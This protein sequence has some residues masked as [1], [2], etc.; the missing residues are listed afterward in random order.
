VKPLPVFPPAGRLFRGFLLLVFFVFWTLPVVPEEALDWDFDTLFDEPEDAQGGAPSGGGDL[1]GEVPAAGGEAA[2]SLLTG[3]LRR[4]GFSLDLSYS[5]NAGYSPGWSEAPWFAGYDPQYSHVLGLNLNGYLG[6][7]VRISENFRAQSSLNFSVPGSSL[8][9]SVFYIDYTLL[10]RV[11]FRAGKFTHNWGISPNFAAANLLSRLPQGNSG[12]D[13]FILKADIPI[14]IGGLQ[15]IAL[16]RPGFMAGTT[17]AF[18]E[19]GYGA[20]YNLAFTWADMDAGFFYHRDMPLRFSLSV[21]T[22]VKNTELYFETVEVVRHGTWDDFGVSANLGFAR[23]FLN[24][25]FSV[26]AEVFWNGEDD[27]YYFK[28]KTELEDGSSSPFIPGFNLAWNLVYRPRWIWNLRFALAGRFA[29][30]TSTAY[31]M[32]GLSFAPLSHIDVS[33]GVPIAL[34]GREGRYYKADNADTKG[35]PFAL[36]LLITLKGGYR[37]DRY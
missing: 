8:G 37:L 26:N 31:I 13:P 17:P 29:L 22:T 6:L 11:Y 33:L 30:D 16:T 19:L 4:S 23:S 36:A 5:V 35:R 32:P 25:L 24:D 21:K 14:G 18:R 15:M 20:K 1:P 7:D 27:A 10:N 12:G 34:G 9:L 28:P 2:G 3:L